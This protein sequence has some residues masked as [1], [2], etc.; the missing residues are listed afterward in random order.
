MLNDFTSDMRTPE[1]LR[2]L[3]TIDVERLPLVPGKTRLE[4]P[5]FAKLITSLSGPND[6]A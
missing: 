2:T 1:C 3:G 4:V 5:S 6:H